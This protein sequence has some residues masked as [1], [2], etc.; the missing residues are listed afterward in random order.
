MFTYVC[1]STMIGFVVHKQYNCQ[2]RILW[3][4]LVVVWIDLDTQHLFQMNSRLCSLQ[5]S[6]N[7]GWNAAHCLNVQQAQQ[8]LTRQQD[9]EILL[10]LSTPD[11]KILK[12]VIFC[13]C[14][15]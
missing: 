1:D 4:S 13:T 5:I 7:L 14:F 8:T 15:R 10:T 3:H 6:R 2:L 12:R 11:F 9:S